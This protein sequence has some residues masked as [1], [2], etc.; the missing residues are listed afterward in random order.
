MNDA[1]RVEDIAAYAQDDTLY[2]LGAT[3]H[4]PAAG[5]LPWFVPMPD[6]TIGALILAARAHVAAHHPSGGAR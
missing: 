4:C 6:P 2:E 3:F 5:C 1:V